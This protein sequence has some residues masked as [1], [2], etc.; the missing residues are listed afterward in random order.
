V[1]DDIS[2]CLHACCGAVAQTDGGAVGIAASLVAS[3]LTNGEALGN[4][5]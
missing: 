5:V 3:V 1:A 2:A 4:E